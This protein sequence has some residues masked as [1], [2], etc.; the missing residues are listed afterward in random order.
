MPR[1]AR[2]RTPEKERRKKG[3]SNS[4]KKKARER[5]RD[6][7]GAARRNDDKNETTKTNRAPIFTRAIQTRKR[8]RVFVPISSSPSLCVWYEM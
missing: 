4:Y 2:A 7:D 5:E 3:N 8:V 6:D 1:K